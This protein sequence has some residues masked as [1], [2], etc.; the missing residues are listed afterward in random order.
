MKKKFFLISVVFA[1]IQ[2]FVQQ[3]IGQDTTA[4][5]DLRKCI[6]YGLEHNIQIKKAVLSN[7]VNQVNIK[8]ARAERFPSVSASVSQNFNWN[9]SLDSANTYGNYSGTNGTNYGI[10][11]NVTLYNGFK[12]LNNIKQS[13]LEYKA[14]TFDIKSIKEDVCLNIVDAYLQLLYAEE[15]VK[16]SEQQIH[17]TTEQLNLA[18]ERLQIG[19]ISKS[20]FQQVKAE[21][22]NEKL[23][24]ANASNLVTVNRLT[25]MQL[26]EL[27]VNS[28][29]IIIQPTINENINENRR[30]DSDS[31]FQTALSVKPQIQSAGIKLE[32][33]KLDVKIAKAGYQ[34]LLSL[35]G[36]VNTGYSSGL[37]GIDYNSQVSNKVNPYVGLT[38]SIPIYQNRQVKSSVSIARIGIQTAELSLQNEQNTL[39][40]TIELAC[41]DVIS[42]QKEF[43]ANV[44]QFDAVNESFSLVSEKYSQGLVNSVDFLFEKAKLIS[45]QSTLLQAK[46][47]LI[48]RY[49][50]LDFYSGVLINL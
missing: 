34:P 8:K 7:E 11:S 29:F 1:F 32:S 46:Y 20:D 30:P 21:L 35:N 13:E 3:L 6:D 23:T 24:M 19:V 28:Q 5:W 15:Q 38:L 36:G 41:T 25:L 4:T 26:L 14:G 33:S 40:K 42:A 9:R 22:A 12:T 17:A 44:E 27:P 47:N 49:K 43:E 45:A 31:I 48:F 50:I 2:L 37:S 39:R 18:N 16:N 10:S